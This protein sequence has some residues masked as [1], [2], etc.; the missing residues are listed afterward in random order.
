MP[1]ALSHML[2]DICRLS[3]A[4]ARMPVFVCWI[5]CASYCKFTVKSAYMPI[6]V[7]VSACYIICRHMSAQY[8]LWDAKCF[9]SRVIWWML[10][11]KSHMP[12]AVSLHLYAGTWVPSSSL[13]VAKLAYMSNCNISVYM[14]NALFQELYAKCYGLYAKFHMLDCYMPNAMTIPMSFS[15]TTE[16]VGYFI[17]Y[18]SITWLWLSILPLQRR[19]YYY[20]TRASVYISKSQHILYLRSQVYQFVST[21]GY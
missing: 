4:K 15:M 5:P 12:V 21:S 11:A 20:T 10:Y 14:P 19:N 1:N 17:I 2:C 18:M 8:L 16:Q 7:P 13:W 9:I 6:S 3:Y